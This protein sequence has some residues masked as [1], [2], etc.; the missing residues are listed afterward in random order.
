MPNEA[1]RVEALGPAERIINS[2]TQYIDHAVHNRPGFI[3][4]DERTPTGVR[5]Q[6]ATWVREGDEQVVY[7]VRKVRGKQQ[8]T[9]VGVRQPNND[10][11]ER[12][13]HVGRWQ[14]AGLFGEVVAYLYGQIASVWELDNEFAARWAS[15]AFHHEDSRDL[16]V[17]LAAFLLVQGR[18][19]EPVQEGDETFVDDDYRAV[20]EA[21][22]LLRDKGKSFNPKLL[23]RVGQVLELPEVAEINRKLGFGQSGRRPIMGRY[24]KM[25]DKWLRHAERNP[26]I[27]DDLVRGGFRTS[28][29]A[30]ARKVGF[31][32]EGER[33]FEI[34][35]WKQKQ[36][37]DGRRSIALGKEV[38]EA[39]SWEALSEQ[40]ICEAIIAER[41]S[42][43]VIAGRLPS[44]I[45]LT[46]AIMAA[47][48]EAECL[49]DQDL[50][51]I[52][53]TLEELGLLEDPEIHERWKAATERVENQRAENIAKN[54]R[55]KVAKE[56]LEQT[57]DRV[58][59]EAAS[60]EVKD[61]RVYLFVDKSGSM[62][63]AIEQA[64]EYLSKFVGVFPLEQ[65]HVCVFNT[66]GR[67]VPIASATRAGVA[68]A[69]RG[70]RAG[71]G[72][73]YA[74]G[75]QC[76]VEKY[77][78]GAQEDALFIFV[79]DQGDRNVDYLVETIQ[80]QGV[81]PV[82]F[83]LLHVSSGWGD[84]TIVVDAAAELGIPC[85]EI[86]E[87]IFSDPY[88]VPRT[89]RNIIAATPVR[90]RSTGGPSGRRALLQTI[91]A[92]PLLERPAWA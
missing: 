31:K 42:Y 44:D 84:G 43:K 53:P 9:R 56:T 91:L 46:P 52:T 74:A 49:T 45:G 86:D 28:V 61:L 18:F 40:Q 80:Q 8:R 58:A 63:G 62:E 75:V 2:L 67:E 60:E 35:R 36:A 29:M 27:L 26:K 55:S 5:W 81:R 21:M 69:F 1:R 7:T 3:A 30:L 54:V 24:G 88:A 20:G 50:I 41:P 78:P 37:D 51:I 48:I 85:F 16:K 22:C 89:L 76:L 10:V 25:V 17:M 14:P 73:T 23:L 87:G 57:V 83:G 90:Q 39:N 34:L 66:I 59:A 12:G 92:T 47:A 77:K 33:F 11:M 82:A 71:G 64:K 38:A 65:L 19:G 68:R 32:P 72:T 6:Q 70:H 13:R 4:N 79:G 15:W